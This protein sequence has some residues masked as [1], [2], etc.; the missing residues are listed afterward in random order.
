M[1]KMIRTLTAKVIETSRNILDAVAGLDDAHGDYLIR[2]EAR[3]RHIEAQ[4]R[5]AIASCTAQSATPHEDA[6]CAR[7]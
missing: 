1:L 2:L 3:I 5:A 6:E 4:H 7:T